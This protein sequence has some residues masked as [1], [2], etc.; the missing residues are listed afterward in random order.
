[1]YF[2]KAANFNKICWLT[3]TFNHLFSRIQSCSRG[4]RPVGAFVRCWLWILTHLYRFHL[5]AGK[6]EQKNNPPTFK[7]CSDRI[8]SSHH[9][10]RET[11]PRKRREKDAFSEPLSVSFNVF[12]A[13]IAPEINEGLCKAAIKKEA[14]VAEWIVNSR[15]HLL[16]IETLSDQFISIHLEG[17]KS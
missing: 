4:N 15:H 5:G 12:Q 8:K 7:S 3:E 10:D 11:T 17:D 2:D 16:E 9:L 1:M 6:T 14:T 13:L